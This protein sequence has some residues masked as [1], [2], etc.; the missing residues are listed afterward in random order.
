MLSLGVLAALGIYAACVLATFLFGGL[1]YSVTLGAVVAP[2]VAFAIF[3]YRWKWRRA[4]TS[5]PM[6]GAMGV[7]QVLI[8]ALAIQDSPTTALMWL[9]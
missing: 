2:M 5:W 6:I 9:K 3:I 7:T 4:R 8:A 1:F